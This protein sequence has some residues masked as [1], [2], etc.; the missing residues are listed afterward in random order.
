MIE[1]IDVY[2]EY[3]GESSATL[4]LQGINL[5]I[6]SSTFT[7][8]MGR[9]GCGKSTLLHLI[10]GLD[11]ATRGAVKLDDVDLTQMSEDQL[12]EVRRQKI[13]IVFQFFNLL[14]ALNALEN[15]ALPLTLRGVSLR[16]AEKQALQLLDEVGLADRARHMPHQLS[17]GEQ[18]RVAIARALIVNPIALLADEPTGALDSESGEKALEILRSTPKKFQTALVMATHSQEVG[19]A[20]D[21]LIKM[22]D[23]QIIGDE[24]SEKGSFRN[25]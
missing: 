14:P 11:R 21:R 17:G 25:V 8:L 20:S 13:G 6:E 15:T 5:K 16:K 10:G 22:K 23:G 7:A 19:R 12:T 1:L 2:K 24:L 4:A 9:S 3:P 18:Q